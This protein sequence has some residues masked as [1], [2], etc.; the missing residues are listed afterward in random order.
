MDKDWT[1]LVVEDHDDSSVPLCAILEAEGYHCRVA[2][3]GRQAVSL[4]KR[5]RPKVILLDIGLPD[6]SGIEVLRAL[7][8]ENAVE[9]CRVLAITGQT[10][11]ATRERCRAVGVN[12]FFSKPIDPES[13]LATV[14]VLE[15]S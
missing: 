5:L 1:I 4:A 2:R 6:I 12:A 7:R 3:T 11:E 13:V 14:R 15:E 8:D 10:D 9:D